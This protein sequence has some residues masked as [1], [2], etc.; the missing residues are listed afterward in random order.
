MVETMKKDKYTSLMDFY[1]NLMASFEA[2]GN[3]KI[4][5]Q[6]SLVRE[7]LKRLQSIAEDSS[8]KIPKSKIASGIETGVFD[9]LLIFCN[10]APELEKE[11]QNCFYE[12]LSQYYPNFFEE[13]DKKLQRVLKKNSLSSEEEALFVSSYVDYLTK[14]SPLNKNLPAMLK[15]VHD[16]PLFN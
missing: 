1:L 14:Y 11:L 6:T 9:T 16:D 4:N 7:S 12:N 3:Q 10:L 15:L 5:S 13:L 2:F 8:N